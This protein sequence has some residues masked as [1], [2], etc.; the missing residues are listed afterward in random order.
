MNLSTRAFHFFIFMLGM[1]VSLF[2]QKMDKR[3]KTFTV[4]R[5]IPAPAEKVWQFIAEDYGAIANSHP[6]IWYADYEN[7][8]LKGELGAQ[9]RCDFNK[10][11][12]KVLHEKIV[13]WNPEKMQFTNRVLKAGGFPID[14]D[15]T[16]AFYAV[17]EVDAN[18]SVMSFTM[19]FRTKPAFMGGMAKGRFTKLIEDYLLA[20]EHHVTTGEVVNAKTGNFKEIKKQY[21]R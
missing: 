19:Q 17:K 8:S 16:R 1:N 7:G 20:V 14:V 21:S 9:R 5:V 12:T 4:E 15:N 2:A 3:Y 6:K 13:D 10:K 11:G 18:K